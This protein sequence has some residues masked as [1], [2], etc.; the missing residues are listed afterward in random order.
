M[1]NMLKL[2]IIP[3]FL[4][5]ANCYQIVA[6]N[7]QDT[8]RPNAVQLPKSGLVGHCKFDEGNCAIALDHSGRGN[9]GVIHGAV[10]AEGKVCQGLKFDGYGDSVKEKSKP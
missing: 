8:A 3:V 1:K 7:A 5:W 9:H 10:L 2:L 4:I 6:V